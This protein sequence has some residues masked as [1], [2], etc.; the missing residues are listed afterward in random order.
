M[1]FTQVLFFSF[2]LKKLK[3]ETGALPCVYYPQ[4]ELDFMFK[5]IPSNTVNMFKVFHFHFLF[6]CF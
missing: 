5:K 4:N 3:L 2:I 1:F 6:N